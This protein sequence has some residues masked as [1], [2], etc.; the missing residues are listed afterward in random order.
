[1]EP[2]LGVVQASTL[3]LVMLRVRQESIRF[4]H[5]QQSMENLH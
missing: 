1:M 2:E 3:A 5:G 4:C